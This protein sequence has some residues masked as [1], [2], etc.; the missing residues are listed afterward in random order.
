MME[1]RDVMRGEQMNSD[2]MGS[3]HINTSALRTKVAT[4][5]WRSRPQ[6]RYEIPDL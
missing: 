2:Q 6:N 1:A 5:N 4:R 3:T